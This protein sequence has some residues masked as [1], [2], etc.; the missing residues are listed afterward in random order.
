M[1][2]RSYRPYARNSAQRN[3]CQEH[4]YDGPVPQCP[5]PGCSLGCDED[6]VAEK[7]VGMSDILWDRTEWP[8]FQSQG[9]YSWESDFYKPW[10]QAPTTIR[11]E[12]ARRRI[13]EPIPEIIY[14]YTDAASLMGMVRTNEMW[15]TDFSFLNDAQEFEH[16]RREALQTIE[17][18][19]ESSPSLVSAVAVEVAKLVEP[20]ELRVCVGSFSSNGDSLSQWRAYGHLAIGLD[21]SR[22]FVPSRSGLLLERVIYEPKKKAA[23]LSFVF[24]HYTSILQSHPALLSLEVAATSI[25]RLLRQEFAFLKDVGFEDER[26]IRAA[27]IEYPKEIWPHL[28][29]MAP[30]FFRVSGNVIVPYT[31]T[32]ALS[33]VSPLVKT[34]LPIRRIVVGPQ[35]NQDVVILGIRE[36]LKANQYDVEVAPSS[37]P[38]RHPSGTAG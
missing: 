31:T 11:A 34:P 9:Y 13:R 25:A 28:R 5:W 23:F 30:K 32:K 18:F 37:I 36:F 21:S 16:G 19:R 29:D 26:E 8:A 17:T 33:I 10:S 35:P 22:L 14:H 3:R 7:R 6:G 12:I 2:G 4:G 27:Y 1:S 20:D 24:H 38:Y 15:L